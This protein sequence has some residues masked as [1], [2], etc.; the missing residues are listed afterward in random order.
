MSMEKLIEEIERLKNIKDWEMNK[1]K[2]EN[3]RKEY[4]G[5]LAKLGFVIE[6]YDTNY[7]I[8]E[9]IIRTGDNSYL[10]NRLTIAFDN[11]GISDIEL[12]EERSDYVNG[13]FIIKSKHT[14]HFKSMEELLEE[15]S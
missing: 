2:T 5:K 7:V 4:D 12:F 14:K 10:N 1:M 15:I 8:Y 3:F 9:R 6:G 11:T 13:R